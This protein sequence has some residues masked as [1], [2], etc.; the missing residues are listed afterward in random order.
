MA[1]DIYHN[2]VKEALITD[3]W[4]V[5]HDP[6]IIRPDQNTKYEIDLSADKVI[7]ATKENKKIAV[8]IK[9]FAGQSLVYEFHSA[10]GQFMNYL[11]HIE[12]VEKDRKLYLALSEKA[13]NSLMKHPSLIEVLKRYKVSLIIFEITTKIITKWINY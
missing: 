10:L 6:Y 5:T 3:G 2:I 11:V 7:A 13:Y 9:S 4:T 12:N 8:E 1:K